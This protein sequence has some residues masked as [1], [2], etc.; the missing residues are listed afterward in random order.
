MRTEYNIGDTVY[1]LLED[2]I[3]PVTITAITANKHGIK[4]D[5]EH[6]NPEGFKIHIGIGEKFVFKKVSDVIKYLMEEYNDYWRIKG[7]YDL[8][9]M[10]TNIST[11]EE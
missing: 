11:K 10:P 9:R 3:R 6:V 2:V 5:I 8:S 1:I 4:Y 7:D